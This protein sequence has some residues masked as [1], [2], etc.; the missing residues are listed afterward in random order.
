M[1]TLI[2]LT[3]M[4]TDSHTAH[5]VAAALPNYSVE[6]MCDN[7]AS[8]VLTLEKWQ[9][10]V[11]VVDVDGNT[12]RILSEL[13]A[14]ITRFPQ[15]R[16]VLLATQVGNDMLV[17]AMQIGARQFLAKQAIA[18]ELPLVVQRFTAQK[19]A[20][21]GEGG[22]VLT[23]LSA[24]G[25]CGA[26]T[27]AVNLANELSLLHGRSL[28]IDLDVAYG[29][30]ATFLGL[31]G[32]YG[33]ADVLS[34]AGQIDA[35]LIQSCVLKYSDRL[36][37]MISSASSN[38]ASPGVMKYE[39]LPEALA[40]CRHLYDYVVI[41]A[42][43][44]Q[45]DIAAMLAMASKSCLIL[46]QLTVKDIRIVR[47]M[48]SALCG[49]GVPQSLLKPIANRYRKS[50]QMISL[51]EEQNAMGDVPLEYTSNDFEHAVRGANYGQLLSEIAPHS[52]FRKELQNL[53]SRF[54]KTGTVVGN[55]TH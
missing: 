18:T 14:V 32:R 44:L 3:L 2:P 48:I 23:L 29:A 51:Q 5:A 55:G 27:F 1:N 28:L 21:N 8:L 13:E 12:S 17:Q 30:I 25:G 7:I 22:T 26:T 41:D 53:A 16:F 35:Q 36:H 20:T 52:I 9:M 31:E 34:H 24:G 45:I 19:P 46:H 33:I 54:A 50:S 10:P 37:V 43:R 40:E 49:R 38:Y 4:T 11:A 39:N 6:R 15:T 42:P 47:A